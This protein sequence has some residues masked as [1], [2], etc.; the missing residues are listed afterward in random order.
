ML[1]FLIF[2]I[3]LTV[4][5]YQA[6]AT[7]LI[8]IFKKKC[9]SPMINVFLINVSKVCFTQVGT[10]SNSSHFATISPVIHSVIAF[11]PQFDIRASARGIADCEISY[12]RRDTAEV[13]PR[14][15]PKRDDVA[16]SRAGSRNLTLPSGSVTQ[17]KQCLAFFPET[18]EVCPR[19][20]SLSSTYLALTCRVCVLARKRSKRSLSRAARGFP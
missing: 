16:C 13:T 10:M 7:L 20:L 9:F 12:R 19:V 11:A 3:Y 4:Y 17:D 6:L 2:S 8:R 18:D 14:S 15:L 5:L 1:L